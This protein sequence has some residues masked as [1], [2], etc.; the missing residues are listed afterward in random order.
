MDYSKLAMSLSLQKEPH[1]LRFLMAPEVLLLAV[2]E[3][4]TSG[5]QKELDS[6]G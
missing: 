3:G 1:T 6:E 5:G 2:T 4:K